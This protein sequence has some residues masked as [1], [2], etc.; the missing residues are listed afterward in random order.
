M[1]GCIIHDDAKADLL[2]IW[3]YISRRSPTDA[4]EQLDR[5][6]ADF[7]TIVANPDIGRERD[8]LMHGLRCLIVGRHLI[9]YLTERDKIQIKRVLSGARDLSKIV[10]E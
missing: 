1:T 7:D 8:V 10:F 9:F 6:Y 5:L 3:N 2:D 4:D